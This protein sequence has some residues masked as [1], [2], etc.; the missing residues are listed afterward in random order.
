MIYPAAKIGTIVKG[1]YCPLK[2][3]FMNIEYLDFGKISVR[4][5]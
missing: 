4:P 2:L 5:V 3:D 1:L